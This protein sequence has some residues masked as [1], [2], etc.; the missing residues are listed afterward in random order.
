MAAP[1]TLEQGRF[2]L[3]AFRG[4]PDR[5]RPRMA[6]VGIAAGSYNEWWKDRIE[7]AGG[8]GG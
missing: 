5:T 6:D 3:T 7:G 4:C 8:D 2:Y 1:G